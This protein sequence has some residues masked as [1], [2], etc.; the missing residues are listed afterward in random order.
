[1]LTLFLYF[2]LFYINGWIL[3][4]FM[5][6]GSAKRKKE[7]KKTCLFTKVG[8][9]AWSPWLHLYL[10][11]IPSPLLLPLFHYHFYI[12]PSSLC[13]FSTFPDILRCSLQP[14]HP[15]QRRPEMNPLSCIIH[16]QSKV[17]KR[18]SAIVSVSIE[19]K[20]F[21]VNLTPPDCRL[22][23]SDYWPWCTQRT[24]K[25]VRSQLTSALRLLLLILNGKTSNSCT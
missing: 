7:E 1:M 17:L 20:C 16:P 11:E 14:I 21:C 8:F 15:Q 5:M 4:V 25:P 23:R 10:W 2:R 19:R 22:L 9:T 12:P 3:W 18:A 24:K 13:N 6:G